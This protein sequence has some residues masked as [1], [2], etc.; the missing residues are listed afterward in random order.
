MQWRDSSVIDA[1]QCKIL[2]PEDPVQ[3]ESMLTI[4]NLTSV[5]NN[6]IRNIKN[7]IQIYLK[8]ISVSGS[9]IFIDDVG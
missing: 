2:T 6:S 9:L 5:E 4:L 3:R 1:K 7:P 8:L